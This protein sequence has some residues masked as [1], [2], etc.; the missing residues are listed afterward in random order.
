MTI[1]GRRVVALVI[2]AALTGGGVFLFTSSGDE[3]VPDEVNESAQKIDVADRTFESNDPVSRGC[4]LDLDI[5]TRI[6]RG[7]VP[8]HTEDLLFV[9][10]APNYVGTFGIRS[11]SG[12][13]DYL[14]TIPLVLYGPE[15]IVGQGRALDRNASITD[16][17][18]TVGRLTGVELPPR[19]GQVLEDALKPDVPGVP[20]LVL[21]VVWDGVGRNMLERW[22]DAWPNLARMERKGTSYLGATV[23]SSPSITPATHSNLGTGAWPKDHDVTSITMRFGDEIRDAFAGR[24]PSDEKLTTFADLIDLAFGNQ[25]LV[26]MLAWKSWHLGML[27]H[28]LLTPGGDRDLLGLVGQS[29]EITGNPDYYYT[30]DYLTPFPGLDE[31][32]EE[33]DRDDG[34]VDGLWMGHDI[35]KLHDNPAWVNYMGDALLETMEQE[36]FGRD[37]IPDLLFTNFKMTDIVGH[38]YSMD[39]PEE[40]VVLQAQDEVLGRLLRYL[41]ENVGDYVV[42]LVADHGHTASTES[43]GAW[44]IAKGALQTDLL[45]FLDVGEEDSPVINTSAVGMFIDAGKLAATGKTLDDVATWM[46]DY[47]LKDNWDDELPPGYEDRA[48]EQ[49]MSA[50]F[51]T[52]D[53]PAIM[54]CA[55]SRS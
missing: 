36:G 26:G 29:E 53:L 51:P 10:Q 46:N 50:A 7:T 42:I 39:S 22:P 52:S 48:G 21:T 3:K 12:P 27:G 13:W 8:E 49:V 17:Y 2:V 30:P 9:P 16:V 23:G 24:I 25:S 32:V 6:D 4:A 40:P 43:S 5:L 34:E 18:P 20:K 45:K 38:Q 44:P 28:G 41:K 37:D 31:R 54:S 14:Q 55:R 11:H 35:A 19:R 47:R 15:R 1:R 33:L